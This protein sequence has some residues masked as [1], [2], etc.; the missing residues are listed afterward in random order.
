[1]GM[2]FRGLQVEEVMYMYVTRH[3]VDVFWCWLSGVCESSGACPERFNTSSLLHNHMIVSLDLVFSRLISV[4]SH[5]FT[6]LPGRCHYLQ[7][8]QVSVY[9]ALG[10]FDP[11]C[12]GFIWKQN[13]S[14]DRHC[15][16]NA[17]LLHSSLVCC[18]WSH[19]AAGIVLTV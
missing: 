11:R 13:F 18:V 5:F 14:I 12:T 2:T 19:T 1:M 17:G 15:K 8:Q 7:K 9:H 16:G 4:S 6:S 10:S 3:A